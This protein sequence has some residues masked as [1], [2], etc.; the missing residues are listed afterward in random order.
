MDGPHQAGAVAFAAELEAAP[1]PSEGWRPL[2]PAG[3]TVRDFGQPC[4]DLGLYYLR[5]A[6]GWSIP[7]PE[8]MEFGR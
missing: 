7:R 4:Q 5:V 1:K 2:Q 8:A 3:I 6:T